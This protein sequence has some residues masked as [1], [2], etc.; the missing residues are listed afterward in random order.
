MPRVNY[1][2]LLCAV[3]FST[4]STGFAIGQTI[5][6]EPPN[7]VVFLV[8]DMGWQDTSV[9][10]W[11]KKTI[12]NER[13]RTPN[14]ERLAAGGM[15][16]TNAYA[17][18][19][20][21]PTRISL[22]TGMNAAHHR[23]T[24]WTNIMRDKTTDSPD[25]MFH[26]VDWNINGFSP[27]KGMPK[28]VVATPLPALLRDEGYF[29][30]HIGKAHWGSMGTPGASPYNAGFVVNKSGHAAGHPQ[31][32]YGEQHYGNVL[33][34]AT[35]HAVPGLEEY[36]Q[37]DVFLTEALTREAI[38]SLEYPIARKQPFF[39]YLAHYALHTPIQGDDRFVKHYLAMGMDSI[40]A[41]YASLIEG[42]DK[43]LGDV[44]DFLE[45][46][47]QE[48]NTIIIF[49]SDNGGLSISPP[50]GG[51]QHTHNLP[52]REGKGSLHEGG[53]RIPMLVKWPGAVKAGEVQEQYVIV[54]DLFPSVLEMAG[55]SSPVVTQTVDGKSFVPFLKN[56]KLREQS[57]PVVWHYPNKWG[58]GKGNAI[59]YASAIRKGKWK[60]IYLMQEERLELY[61]LEKDIGEQQN[62]AQAF[63]ARTKELAEELTRLLKSRDALMPVRKAN[64]TPVAW[65]SAR[66]R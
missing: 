3:A 17:T 45:K 30:I 2:M 63:P 7:I 32:Y 34:K 22:L 52:L 39:L 40:E 10:F 24:N 28:T 21:T 20:C 60:L 44:M 55:I 5:P 53:I 6:P 26:G 23:V 57:R 48:K 16:F 66:L 50:R 11:D 13:Y 59:N 42:M 36:Y 27:V 38:K 46:T 19:V 51:V 54:E 62:V 18:P 33:G 15:K 65:P 43:S 25:E 37:S 1:R 8:D 4:L 58:G 56:P 64:D 31:N 14:M 47:D 12:L 41:R 35:Y 49:L 29:T 61:D 9:P